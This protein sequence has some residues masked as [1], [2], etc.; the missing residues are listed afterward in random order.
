[1]YMGYMSILHL[2]VYNS[3]QSDFQSTAL[4]DLIYSRIVQFWNWLMQLYMYSAFF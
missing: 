4:Q 1:M 3:I 2:Q